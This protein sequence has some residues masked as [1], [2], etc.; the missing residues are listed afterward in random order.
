[1]GL[2]IENLLRTTTLDTEE[3]EVCLRGIAQVA[4]ADGTVDPRERA[5]LQKFVDEFFPDTDSTDD[6]WNQAVSEA[7]L[8]R[9]KS[10]A[11]RQCFLGYG[12]ITAY[13]DEDFADAEEKLLA[14]WADT[15]VAAEL[16]D[17]IVTAVREFLYRRAV[18]AYAFR[19]GRLDDEFALK[20][21]TRFNV[22]TERAKELNAGVFNAIMTIRNPAQSETPAGS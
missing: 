7:D 17:A 19:L 22:P 15:L 16:R 13:I 8:Q 10:E 1:M 9:L 18:F 12:Y 6:A 4:M 20:A 14:R 5:Y 2:V 11:A 3:R 21:A